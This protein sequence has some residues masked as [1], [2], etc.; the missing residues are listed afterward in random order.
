MIPKTL[1]ILN[2]TFVVRFC[3][4][5]K[6]FH[7]I[8]FFFANATGMILFQQKSYCSLISL[9]QYFWSGWCTWALPLYLFLDIILS[10]LLDESEAAAAG[11]DCT[12]VKILQMMYTWQSP[13]LLLSLHIV[14]YFVIPSFQI[15]SGKIYIRKDNSILFKRQTCTF[16][17]KI[18]SL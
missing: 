16:W 18:K 2:K 10:Y 9:S 14:F 17:S 7:M 15:T 13:A 6:L 1:L 4:I 8:F 11:T 3:I 5:T 12:V